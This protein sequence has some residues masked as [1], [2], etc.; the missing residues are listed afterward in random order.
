MFQHQCRVIIM[1]LH[2]LLHSILTEKKTHGERTPVTLSH[3][4]AL[5]ANHF[6]EILT[7]YCFLPNFGLCCFLPRS[8]PNPRFALCLGKRRFC[9]FPR[10]GLFFGNHFNNLWRCALF[11]SLM[12][13][14]KKNGVTI[15]WIY[16]VTVLSILCMTRNLFC[17]SRKLQRSQAMAKCPFWLKVS[18]ERVAIPR[19]RT[20]SCVGYGVPC[21]RERCNAAC[22]T[23]G[24]FCW[25]APAPSET[26]FPCDEG[27]PTASCFKENAQFNCRSECAQCLGFQVMTNSTQ[28]FLTSVRS[29]RGM[30]WVYGLLRI[31]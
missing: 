3:N 14:C 12:Q 17:I 26:N 30:L 13:L 8:L 10:R 1:V 2:P 23:A 4:M 29:M 20:F 28:P 5:A 7:S 22:T 11:R 9:H 18:V 6:Q 15:A 16:D 25:P 24:R 31:L 21:E 19:Q 27:L